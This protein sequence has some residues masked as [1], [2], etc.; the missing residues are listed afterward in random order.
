M[1]IRRHFLLAA[2]TPA[3]T[4]L[5]LTACESGPA[6][7]QEAR[8][9]RLPVA[10]NDGDEAVRMREL[11][12]FATLAATSHNTQSWKFRLATK[13]ISLEVDP[14][15]RTPVVDPDDHHLY[16]SLGC[17]TENL[18][19]AALATGL[20]ATSDFDPG[21]LGAIRVALETTKAVTSP[22]YQAITQRQCTR[23][24][25]DG[26]SIAAA[27]LQLL[28]QAG[29]GPGV[30]VMLITDR[31]SI[32]KT[33]EFVVAANS[34]QINDDA[35]VEELKA[36]IRFS[37]DEALRTGDGL[38]TGTTGNPALP[39]WLGSRMLGVFMTPKSDSERYSRQIRSSSGL[40][41]FVADTSDKAHW[42]QVGRCYQRF[43]LQATALGIR[44]A[45]LNQPVEVAAIRPQFAAALGLGSLRPDLAVRFGRGATMPW[46]MRRPVQD[47]LV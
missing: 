6:R 11:V 44:N 31:P 5:A 21:G 32:E 25:Y 26:T 4:T 46:S 27:E 8:R 22:L 34:V 20:Q 30:R 14:L 37:H 15:R 3:A 23:G 2:A 10:Y 9:I 13:S 42:V 36:W 16:V 39:R 47:V 45:F 38:F 18:V 41:V 12:R 43:A 33:L 40:A 29:T 24:D 28:E 1:L 19:H 7:E 17:A 35:F